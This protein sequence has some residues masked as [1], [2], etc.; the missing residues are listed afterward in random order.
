MTQLKSADHILV[1]LM[2]LDD[3]MIVLLQHLEYDG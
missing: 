3:I 2:M 1:L